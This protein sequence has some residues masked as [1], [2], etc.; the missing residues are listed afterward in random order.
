M[1]K[2][3]G[4]GPPPPSFGQKPKEL[5]HFFVKPSFTDKAPFDL[6]WA[7][8]MLGLSDLKKSLE[9]GKMGEIGYYEIL[10]LLMS[11]ICYRR[12]GEKF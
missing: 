1:D 8:K 3:F 10:T 7:A 5:L 6:S 4:H 9:S 11:V 2:T 12:T